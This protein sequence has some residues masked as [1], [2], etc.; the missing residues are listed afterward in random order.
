MKTYTYF[1]GLVIFL[2]MHPAISQS[3]K[4]TNITSN[5][6]LPTAIAN[7]G[8]NSGRLFILEKAGTVEAWNGS[9]LT[10]FLDIT[11][12]VYSSDNETGLL[13]IAFHPSFETNGYFYLNYTAQV[14]NQLTTRIS[15]FHVAD[16]STT[17]DPAS[18]TI[19]LSFAQPF[20]NHNGGALV[21]GDDGYL[22]IATGDGGSGG[23]PLGNGQNL[24][25]VLGKI[26]RIDVDGGSPYSIPEDN[27]FVGVTDAIESI[28]AYGFRNPWRMTKDRQTGAI[29]IGDVGQFN[30]E[31]IDILT[32][33]ANYGWNI[34]EGTTCYNATSCDKTGLTLPVYDFA[35]SGGNCSVTG[36]YVYRGTNGTFT[37]GDYIFS[38]FCSG[39]IW[40]LTYDGNSAVVNTLLTTEYSISSFGENENGELYILD[41]SNGDLYLI[42]PI[43]TSMNKAENKSSLTVFPNPATNHFKVEIQDISKVISIQLFDIQGNKVKQFKNT[44][45]ST[46]ITLNCTNL[47]HGMY[48]LRVN[49]ENGSSQSEQIIIK[50]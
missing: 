9:S 43:V 30:R 17:A 22:Y 4:L 1:L 21:F 50:K 12:K 19:I 35:R 42:E 5:L 40:S 2:F 26:L 36:G 33:G 16:G 18:E 49:Y 27:P 15:R 44:Q 46:P 48:T 13:G 6:T 10:T 28:Y 37:Q 23:D 47:T 39:I 31:E 32:A 7:A 24:E 14:N 41:Y 29:W 11:G 34:M 8:D 3:I 45:T 25:T 20:S 38:D